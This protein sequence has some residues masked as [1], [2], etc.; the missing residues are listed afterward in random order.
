MDHLL[1][2]SEALGVNSELPRLAKRI[3]DRAVAEGH[4]GR[5]YAALVAQFRVPSE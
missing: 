4:G 3:A 5:S 1:H 2:E